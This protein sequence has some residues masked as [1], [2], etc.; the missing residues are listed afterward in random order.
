MFY[1]HSIVTNIVCVCVCVFF[2]FFFFSITEDCLCFVLRPE[3][4]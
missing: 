1:F 3:H 4:P 2:F